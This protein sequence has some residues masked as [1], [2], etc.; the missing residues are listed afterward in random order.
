MIKNK[1]SILSWLILF[2]TLLCAD[3][4]ITLE[5][6]NSKPRS[7]AKDYYIWRFLDQNIT[8]DQAELALAQVCRMNKKLFLKFAKKIDDKGFKKSAKCLQAKEFLDKDAECIEI[9]LTPYKAS[10]LSTQEIKKLIKKVQKEYPLKAM[11]LKTIASKKSFTLLTQN[12]KEVFFEVFNNIGKNYRRQKLNHKLPKDFLDEISKDERFNQTVK[13]ITT[14]LKL[15]NLQKSIL[16]VNSSHLSSKTNFFL[17]L[18][19]LRH[20]KKDKALKY[21][22]I[23]DKKAYYR[24]DKDKILF[25]KYL[26]TKDLEY[27]YKASESF[28]LNIYSLYA[29]E[30]LGIKPKNII[31]KCVNTHKKSG[32]DI[33]DPFEWYETLQLLK[34]LDKEQ[35]LELSK[36]FDSRT[37]APHEAFLLEKANGYHKHYFI[38]PYFEYL[39]KYD[40]EKTILILAIARQE[41]RFIPACVSTSYALGMMQFM[42]FV[43][44]DIAKRK[45]INFSLD[46]MFDPKTAYEFANFHLDYLMRHLNHPLFVAY[47]YN[48]G[49]GFAKRVLKSGLFGKGK[50]EPFLSM[51]LVPYDESKRYGKKVLANYVIYAQLLGIEQ[52]I[53]PLLKKLTEPSRIAHFQK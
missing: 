50:Y 42:P 19:A 49:M 53:T 41:S 5:F 22:D 18:N 37:T 2:S 38:M 39:K 30:K 20:K 48:G 33:N 26:V 24:F 51:E 3:E 47:A 44:K 34:E 29:L 40:K 7:I 25:W 52:K 27:L 6:L 23:S 4:K 36:Y 45:K 1:I 15:E 8:S 31:S 32:F 14:D 35:I 46:D 10:K 9:G 28:D 21:L 11:I 17:F 16:D 43:A 12:T 13:L